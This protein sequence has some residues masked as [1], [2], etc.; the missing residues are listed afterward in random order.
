MVDRAS[1]RAELRF[2]SLIPE[3]KREFKAEPVTQTT[4]I[5]RI[6]VERITLKASEFLMIRKM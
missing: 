5:E 3:A 2:T 4:P 6:I 1:T